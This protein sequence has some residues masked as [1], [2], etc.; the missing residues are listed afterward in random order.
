MSDTLSVKNIFLKN[1]RKYIGQYWG[2]SHRAYTYIRKGESGGRAKTGSWGKRGEG[3]EYIPRL[4]IVV[5]FCLIYK[6]N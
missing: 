1:L 2:F 4:D 6:A 3:R 5:H